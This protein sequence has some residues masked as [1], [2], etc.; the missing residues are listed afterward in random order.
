MKTS[1]F[2]LSLDALGVTTT[3]LSERSSF[4]VA[5]ER[6]LQQKKVV[7]N[8]ILFLSL[9]SVA[10]FS[11]FEYLILLTALNNRY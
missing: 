10:H 3:K 2:Y 1:S 6:I 11:L 5:A 8:N 7:I 9:R 4:A